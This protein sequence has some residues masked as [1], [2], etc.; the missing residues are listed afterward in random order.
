MVAVV[1][2][3][4]PAAAHPK[5]GGGGGGGGSRSLPEVIN[6]PAGWQPEGV[7]S[8]VGSTVYAG[9]LANGA[10]W[11]GNL[12]TGKGSVLIPGATGKVAVGLKYSRGLIFV[13]GGPTGTVT[14]YDARTGAQVYSKQPGTTGATFV[15]DVTVTRNAAWFTDSQKAVLY[16]VALV[17]GK[18]VGEPSQLALS[19][20]WSQVTGFNA[21][22]IAASENGRFLLV[23]NST[24]G[25]VYR[26]N[27][28]TGVARAV[29]TTADLTNGDG[30]LLRGRELDVVRNQKNEVVVLRLSENLRSARVVRTLTDP[31]FA[32]PT[33]IT[34][35]G[36]A[37]YAVNAK[38]GTTPTPTTPYEIVRVDGSC[39]NGARGD[40]PARG[41]GNGHG[42]GH[43]HHSGRH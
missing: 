43:G 40:H 11:R 22:G 29:V 42:S 6:L 19:G 30:L 15:N 21:N 38:F 4:A 2:M 10:I 14:V 23:V 27:A 25:K 8:G 35:Y 32:V 17:R 18:P 3:S 41:H 13:A 1:A 33:T 24:V 37:L 9:S 34:S 31:D 20:D 28:R 7:A 12:R 39:S 26:V 5:G 36:C 16:K